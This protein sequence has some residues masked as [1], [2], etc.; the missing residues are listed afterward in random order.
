[1]NLLQ[2]WAVLLSDIAAWFTGAGRDAAPAPQAQSRE[3]FFAARE[4]K[5]LHKSTDGNFKKQEPKKQ[6]P[7]TT[8]VTLCS[9]PLCPCL[10][11]E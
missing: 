2:L 7:Q 5:M 1:M 8:M 9:M 11:S 3:C 6:E 4:H 10:R